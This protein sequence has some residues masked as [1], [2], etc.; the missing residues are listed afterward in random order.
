GP[1][2]LVEACVTLASMTS[3]TPPAAGPEGTLG[4][5][6]LA[7]AQDIKLSHSIFALPFALLA[8]FLAPAAAHGALPTLPQVGLIV[9]CMV[10]ARTVAMTANRW[11]DAG[12]DAINPRTVRR[13]IPAGRLTRQFVLGTLLVCAVG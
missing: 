13:A 5:R 6:L 3:K 4:Q 7:V 1:R 9:L 10:L 12:F 11:A 8:T 2:W